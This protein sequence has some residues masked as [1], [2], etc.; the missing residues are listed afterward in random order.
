MAC[1]L[2][3][4]ACLLLKMACWLTFD[5]ARGNCSLC[6]KGGFGCWP[7]GG[8]V[9]GK[10]LQ[11]TQDMYHVAPEWLVFSTN[12]SNSS[13]SSESSFSAKK[14]EVLVWSAAA[15]QCT[16]TSDAGSDGPKTCPTQNKMKPPAMIQPEL[17]SVMM[18][19]LR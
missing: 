9:P 11:P 14:N 13:E 18:R 15:G 7:A 3:K 2:L 19:K 16:P 4:M 12:G 6:A 8:Y 10:C 1:L 17:A 5:L